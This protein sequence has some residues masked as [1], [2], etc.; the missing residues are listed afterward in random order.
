MLLGEAISK[1]DHIAGVP[2]MPEIAKKMYN[3]YLAKGALATTAIEGNTLT[4]EEAVAQLEGRLRL[5]PSREYLSRELQN[6]VDAC[7]RI[8]EDIFVRNDDSISVE[9]MLSMNAAVL[10]GLP[11]E[12]EVSPGAFRQHNVTVGKHRCAPWED[13]KYLSHRLVDFLN[14]FPA[15]VKETRIFAVVKAVF[16]HVYLV[17]IHPF[18]DGNG[19]TARLLEF[20]ILMSGGFPAPACHLLSNH[21]NKTRTEYY[22]HLDIASSNPAD[23]LRF[24]EYALAGFV[25]GLS[26]QIEYIRE[27]Q[28]RVSWISYIHHLYAGR[29]SKIEIRRRDLLLALPDD[30]F[31]PVDRIPSLSPEMAAAY[32]NKVLRTI[33]RDI[34]KLAQANLVEIS[35]AGIRAK[36][37]NIL[38]FL[39]RHK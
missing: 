9:I 11:M 15:P 18:A 31:V 2:L 3:L 34:D 37:E 30:S 33:E 28:W 13:C 21:Y 35:P 26:E 25:D 4:E 20:N 29:I 1:C 39:P 14:D 32:G 5:P 36:K 8:Q 27:Q 10:K 17:W 38:A 7:N 6:I 12:K 24:L 16:A 22:R 23:I 19:R